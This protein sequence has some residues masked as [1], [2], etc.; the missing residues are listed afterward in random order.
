M[1][2][3]A[4]SSA[5]G[6]EA[7]EAVGQLVQLHAAN[8]GGGDDGDT[9]LHQKRGRQPVAA[10]KRHSG[11]RQVQPEERG[12]GGSGEREIGNRQ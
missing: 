9:I 8:V 11:L 12:R 2:V 7:Q 10:D 4:S 5:V 1:E 3:Q 6:V